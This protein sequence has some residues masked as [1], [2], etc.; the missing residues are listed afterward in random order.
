MELINQ[1]IRIMIKDLALEDKLMRLASL[2]DEKDK[3]RN[4]IL[5]YIC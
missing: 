5:F 4:K 1:S 3:G 2:S